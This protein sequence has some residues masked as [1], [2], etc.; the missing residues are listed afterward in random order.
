MKTMIKKNVVLA[1][2]VVSPL[3]VGVNAMAVDAKPLV[4]Q[5][6]VSQMSTALGDTIAAYD[7]L[8]NGNYTLA[9]TKLDAAVRSLESALTKDPTL[10][11]TRT[12]GRS[13]L[14]ELKDVRKKF[15]STNPQPA[16]MELQDVLD[17]AG[18]VVN[19]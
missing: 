2:A 16:K 14:R 12:D 15:S 11:V 1:A 18:I 8:R 9:R 7:N 5:R 10:G 13:L 17:K 3:F 4:D 19:S 6:A